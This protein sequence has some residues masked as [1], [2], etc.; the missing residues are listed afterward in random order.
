M[1]K[2]EKDLLAAAKG[3]KI[4]RLTD[5]FGTYCLVAEVPNG[6]PLIFD[7]RHWILASP[8]IASLFALACQKAD[9]AQP[10][11]A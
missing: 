6:L 5:A 10:S 1:T 2:D 3:C 8:L 4:H 7:G 9:S 11:K